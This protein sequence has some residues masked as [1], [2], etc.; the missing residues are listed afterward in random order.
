MTI[1]EGFSS[2]TQLNENELEQEIKERTKEQ[3]ATLMGVNSVT[4][5][6]RGL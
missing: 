2:R 5:E 4:Q 1:R 6:E 3:N